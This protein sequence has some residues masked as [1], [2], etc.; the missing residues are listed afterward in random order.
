MTT[1]A[2]EP[3]KL[4]GG[5]GTVTAA[6]RARARAVLRVAIDEALMPSERTAAWLRLTT[7]AERAGTDLSAYLAAHIL[8]FRAGQSLDAR[9]A[10]ADRLAA[11][12]G[13]A[14]GDREVAMLKASVE[15]RV[16]AGAGGTNARNDDQWAEAVSRVLATKRPRGG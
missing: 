1:N 15:L 2:D 10:E 13:E 5:R 9:N 12:A 16:T 6:Q 7:Y 11:L 8:P 4:A 14:I 3:P